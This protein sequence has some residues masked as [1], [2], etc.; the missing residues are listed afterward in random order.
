MFHYF[1]KL[2]G[3]NQLGL[4]VLCYTAGIPPYILPPPPPLPFKTVA[5][6]LITVNKSTLC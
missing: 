1:I 6:N 5:P 4:I 3:E 2:F